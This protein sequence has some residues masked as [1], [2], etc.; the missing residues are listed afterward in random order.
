MPI[1]AQPTLNQILQ[2]ARDQGVTQSSLAA[3]ARITPETISRMKASGRGEFDTFARLDALFGQP[4]P[5]MM[6][7]HQ[8]PS[9]TDASS[10]PHW[11]EIEI[12][13]PWRAAGVPRYIA[14]AEVASEEYFN[15]VDP[16]DLAS[17]LRSA[18]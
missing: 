12:V 4:L 17:R 6:W 2:A 13:S 10:P 9:T 18:R 7:L 14:A 8:A 1:S 11:F 5:L 16:A 15:P 3:R